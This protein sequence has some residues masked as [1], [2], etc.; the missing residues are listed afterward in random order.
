MAGIK[1]GRSR[2]RSSSV[3]K[4]YRTRSPSRVRRTWRARRGTRAK[5]FGQPISKILNLP[6]HATVALTGASAGNANAWQFRAN[7]IFDP[8]LTGA[9]HQPLGHDQW[10]LFYN[11]YCVLGSS[12]TATFNCPGAVTAPFYIGIVLTD[13][14]TTGAAS[15][16]AQFDTACE[17]KHIRYKLITSED[18]GKSVSLSFHADVLKFLGRNQFSSDVK[19]TFGSNPT[20]MAYYTLFVMPVDA[21]YT[22]PSVWCSVQLNYKTKLLEPKELT[23]S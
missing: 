12:I 9:G 14:A 22:A 4:R 5:T 21:S 20:E 11:H 18:S 6:Y 13:D 2:T 23:A 7:S 10:T 8:D 19:T 15:G 17:N 3:S 1:R 16:I